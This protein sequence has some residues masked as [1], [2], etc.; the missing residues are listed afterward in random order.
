MTPAIQSRVIDRLID[1]GNA[2]EPWALVVLAAMEGA[3]Q[4]E[5][6]SGR[7]LVRF[8]TEK[9]H[10]RQFIPARA[11]RS[12]DD[13]LAWIRQQLEEKLPAWEANGIVPTEAIADPTN[14][15]RGHRMYGMTHWRDVYSPRQLLCHG[16]TAE[17][18]TELASR[19]E[20]QSFRLGA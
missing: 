14:Y 16:T 1:T 10:E 11:P 7:R 17:V 9:A 5:Q 8:L 2:D 19:P 4:L 13:N 12:E 20:N 15:E 18:I 3:Q 6:F